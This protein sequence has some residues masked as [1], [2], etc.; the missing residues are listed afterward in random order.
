MLYAIIR[1]EFQFHLAG[2]PLRIG[3][4]LTLVLAATSILISARDYNLRLHDFR[5]RA[6]AHARDLRKATVYSYLQPVAMRPPEPLSVLDQGFDAYLGNEVT[7]HLFAIPAEASGGYRGNELLGASPA[8]DLTTIVAV[9]LGLLALLL[10]H[11]AMQ[12]ERESAV[13][14]SLLASGIPR[15]TLLTGKVLGGLLALALPLGGALLVSLA[16]FTLQVEATLSFAQWLRAAGLAAAYALY[17]SFMFLLGLLI[18]IGMHNRLRALVVAV[19]VWLATVVVLPGSA[20]TLIGDLGSMQ[21]G[22]Q[23]AARRSAE[24]LAEGDRRLDTARRRESLR[25]PFSGDHASSF[26]TGPNRAVLYRYGSASY[27]DAL[28]AYYRTEVAT[29]IRYAETAFAERQRLEEK[30]R[31]GERLAAVLS[32]VSP[33]S[34]LEGLSEKLA[35]TSTGDYDRFLTAC[36]SYRLA[37]ADYLRSRNVFSSW[38]WFTDDPPDRLYPWPRFF[39]LSPEEVE[40]GEVRQLFQRF[41]EPAVASRLWREQSQFE[42]DPARRLR[43]QDMPRF[44]S[45]EAGLLEYLRRGAPE[46]LGLL[47]FNAVAGAVVAARFRRWSPR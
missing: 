15:G 13:L 8:A 37:F 46:A 22:R 31:A 24:L 30:L 6:A 1:K 41:G 2:F 23:V 12:S 45:P 33:A 14:P 19:V 11:D 42:K 16:I 36:R 28:S 20:R 25:T 10:A 5:D 35:G 47:T 27:Y 32:L 40:P 21:R 18:S 3:A 4:V 38:R 43:I 29:G 7:I 26:A 39:G 34:L 44:E 17:L 9:V